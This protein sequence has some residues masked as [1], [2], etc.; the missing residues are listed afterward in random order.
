VL[1]L[2]SGG[3]LSTPTAEQ[4]G[5]EIGEG[6]AELAAER[7]PVAENGPN[8]QHQTVHR[9]LQRHPPLWRRA[10]WLPDALCCAM[11]RMM[12]MMSSQELKKKKA[13]PFRTALVRLHMRREEGSSTRSV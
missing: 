10:C 4:S 6:R 3:P 1:C 13:L 11:A 2:W 5:A 7:L 8:E 12:R 9:F